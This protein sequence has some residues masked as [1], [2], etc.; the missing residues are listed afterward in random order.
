MSIHEYDDI[1]G[2]DTVGAYKSGNLASM[3]KQV[4]IEP[5]E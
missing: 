4:G 1:S 3:L 5:K 2:A